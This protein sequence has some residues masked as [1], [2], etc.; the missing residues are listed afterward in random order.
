MQTEYQQALIFYST[1]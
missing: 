1:V